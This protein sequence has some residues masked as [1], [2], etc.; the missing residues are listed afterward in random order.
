[1][2]RCWQ[3]KLPTKSWQY[4]Q[5]GIAMRRPTLSTLEAQADCMRLPTSID[6]DSMGRRDGGAGLVQDQRSLQWLRIRSSRV[7]V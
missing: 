6:V 5:G 4:P 1:M 3:V 7:E 2:A